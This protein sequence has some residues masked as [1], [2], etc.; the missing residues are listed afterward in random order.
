M[1]G[2]HSRGVVLALVLVLL[3]GLALLAIAGMG[4]AAASVAIAGLAE[5]HAIAFEAAEAAVTRSLRAWPAVET[6]G[7]SP[8][9]VEVTADAPATNASQSEGFSIGDGAP[10]LELRHYTITAES[11]A[12]RGAAARV[13]QGFTVLEPPP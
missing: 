12:A 9:S 11:R 8:V 10:G 3:L 13:E 7:E 5:Q 1:T 4:G 6:D 2:R